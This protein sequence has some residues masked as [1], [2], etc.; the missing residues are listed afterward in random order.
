VSFAPTTTG[1]KSASVQVTGTPGGTATA[2]LSGTGLHPATLAISPTQHAFGTLATGTT[3]GAKAFTVTNTGEVPTGTLSSSLVT[4][5]KD[6][7][8]TSNNTCDGVTLAP[9]ATCSVTVSFAPTTTGLKS[10]SLQVGA[11]PGGAATASFSG[12]GAT[13]AAL[14]LSPQMHSFGAVM[15]GTSASKVFTVTNTGGVS[16]G[17]LTTTIE[18]SASGQFTIIDNTCSGQTL[19]AGGTCTL[20][21]SYAPTSP[22]PKSATLQVT[23][24][25]G[26][27][28]NASIVGTA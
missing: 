6:Q 13:P 11:I 20:S 4:G 5:D 25:P 10:S 1:A 16:T 9:A 8:A 15:P 7:F 26:G 24:T 17:A 22:G 2:Q 21:V 27:T 19:V 12:T 14:G 28:A 3:G 18:T 23:A